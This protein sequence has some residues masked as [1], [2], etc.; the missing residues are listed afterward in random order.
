MKIEIWS[1]FACPYCYIGE[2]KLEKALEEL[3]LDSSAKVSF[4]SFQLDVNAVSHPNED[5][6]TLISKKY[7]ISYEQAKKANDGIVATAKEV[8]LNYDFDN[9]KP[10]NTGLAHQLIK[11][12]KTKGKETQFAERLFNAYFVEGIELGKMENLIELASLEGFDVEEV[13]YALNETVYLKE[14]LEDQRMAHELGVSSFPFF[15][16]EDKYAVSGAQSVEYFRMAIEKA[17]NMKEN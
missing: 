13:E 8:G 2:K 7:K 16:I 10:S 6:N 17:L 4:R 9:L 15:V 11:F 1:D 12:A 3:K 14:V 5:I